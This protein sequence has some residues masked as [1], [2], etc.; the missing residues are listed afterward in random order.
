MYPVPTYKGRY[1]MPAIYG[2]WIGVGTHVR[3]MYCTLENPV[4]EQVETGERTRK[5]GQVL[6]LVRSRTRQSHS[7]RE[8]TSVRACRIALTPLSLACMASGGNSARRTRRVDNA[9]MIWLR[10]LDLRAKPLYFGGCG[11]QKCAGAVRQAVGGA[12][13]P[14]EFHHARLV[15]SPRQTTLQGTLRGANVSPV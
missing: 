15:L 14:A 11:W 6:F 1:H 9:Y 12:G 2:V 3:K 8:I 5:E 7:A 4:G 10:D 13:W